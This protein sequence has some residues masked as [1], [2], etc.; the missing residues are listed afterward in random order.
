MKELALGG[1][2]DYPV[3]RLQWNTESGTHTHTHT[4]TRTMQGSTCT[5][6]T[7]DS[8][9]VEVRERRLVVGPSFEVELQPMEIRTFLVKVDFSKAMVR[10]NN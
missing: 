1:N 5:L 3:V 4:H 2:T 9:D 10:R 8:T 7:T 6:F